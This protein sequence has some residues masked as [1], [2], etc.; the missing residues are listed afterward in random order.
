M[1]GQDKTNQRSE[2]ERYSSRHMRR[3]KSAF[4]RIATF[5][6]LLVIA[7]MATIL[8]LMYRKKPEPHFMFLTEEVL[9]EEIDLNCLL[10]RD[11]T[12]YNAPGDGI[13]RALIPQGSKV[14]K[15]M[16]LGQVLPLD[17]MEELRQLDK[18]N[19]DV[20]DRRYELISQGKGGDAQRVFKAGDEEI[21][22]NLSILFDALLDHDLHRIVEI[23]SEIRLVMAQRT[24]DAELLNLD[25]A[26]LSQLI[27]YRDRLEAGSASKLTTVHSEA[28]GIFIRSLDGLEKELNKERSLT[29]TAAEL[30][31][32]LKNSGEA[33]VREEVKSGEPMYKLSRSIEQYFVCLIPR[34]SLSRYLSEHKVYKAYC[35]ANGVSLSDLQIIRLEDSGKGQL[36][37]FSGNDSLE[38]FVS[39]RSAPLRLTLHEVYG[40]RVPKSALLDY[41]EGNIE[42][43]V[44]LVY[45]GFVRE[46]NVKVLAANAHYAIIGQID[47]RRPEGEGEGPDLVRKQSAA[48]ATGGTDKIEP[49]VELPETTGTEEEIPDRPVYSQDSPYPVAVSSIILLN[50]ESMKEGDPIADAN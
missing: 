21:R 41:E 32:Y 35:A 18:A 24:E 12:V 47:S 39:M 43:K 23:D 30:E 38:A 9:S 3:K 16:R 11:E 48:G 27:D 19:S 2:L 26:E 29:M 50:P 44:K 8:I 6:L 36:L 10:V 34:S 7:T 14:S 37:V 46:C 17:S 13:F 5:I 22:R 33:A 25:D 15:G 45:G 31:S 49:S 1:T 42:A 20:H 28:S 4:L 40:L